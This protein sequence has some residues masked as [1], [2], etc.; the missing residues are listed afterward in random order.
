MARAVDGGR[1]LMVVDEDRT[2]RTVLRQAYRLRGHRCV[3]AATAAE[4]LLLAAF[5]PIDVVILEWSF[6]DGSGQGLAGRLRA[7]ARKPLVI[8]V[9]SVFDEP[10]GFREREAIDDYLVKPAT[11][12]A[13]EHA[14]EACFERYS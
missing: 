14:F 13:V 6:R 11:A 4:A 9:L 10:H 3:A 2:S 8:V 7:R 12:E 1:R 5:E